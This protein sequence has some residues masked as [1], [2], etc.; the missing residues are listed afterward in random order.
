MTSKKF[1]FLLFITPRKYQKNSGFRKGNIRPKWVNTGNISPN[2]ADFGCCITSHTD[3]PLCGHTTI[4]I[5]PAILASIESSYI[6][7]PFK[8]FLF[9]N[10]FAMLDFIWLW[11]DL[12]SWNLHIWCQEKIPPE[13]SPPWGVRGGVRVRLG[14]GLGLESGG[15]FSGGVF[16]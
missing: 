5:C 1:H 9:H 6:G 13:K 4:Y 15:L 11:F 12:K 16:S 8:K 2:S 3:S 10:Q 7:F 14:I